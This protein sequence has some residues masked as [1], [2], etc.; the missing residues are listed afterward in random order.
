MPSAYRAT[1]T[2]STIAAGTPV[3]CASSTAAQTAY[4][5]AAT[6]QR[7][8]AGC[9]DDEQRVDEHRVERVP[10][11]VG[12]RV[13]DPRHGDPDDDEPRGDHRCG[14]SRGFCRTGRDDVVALVGSA[15]TASTV[16]GAAATRV[17]EPPT[18]LGVPHG[19]RSCDAAGA[20]LDR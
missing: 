2:A 6:T 15:V 1:G 12:Q 18:A 16:R 11:R 3:S 14:C 4:A 8:G 5:T 13:R 19:A 9:D 7:P 17:G 10:R 20:T